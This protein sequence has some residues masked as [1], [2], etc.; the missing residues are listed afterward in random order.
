MIIDLHCDTVY[1]L[2]TD[3]STDSLDRN[4]CS[5]DAERMIKGGVS[6]QCFAIFTPINAEAPSDGLTD[7]QRMNGIHDRFTAELKRSTQLKQ[8]FSAADIKNDTHLAILTVEEL[9]PLEGKIERLEEIAS[10]GVRISGL[11]W[12]WENVYGYPNSKDPGIMSK[13]LK[14]KGFEALEFFR[15][16]DI[17][18]DVS[19][20][21]DGG[22]YDVINS[23]CKVLAT[24][25]NS[26]AITDVTRNLTDEMLKALADK[27]GV[28]GLNFCPSF[29]TS[30][31]DGEEHV[32]RVSDM[33]RHVMH[34]YNT[35]G[36]DVLALGTDFD[37]I[38]GVLEIPSPDY[39]YL[40]WDALRSAGLSER[41][42][43]KMKGTNALRVL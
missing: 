18:V 21:S 1:K 27:G 31:S 5:V 10:W 12:N 23:G 24:H 29:L 7:W 11:T 2:Y 6:G 35:A 13:G 41:I 8:A 17:A 20:L 28:A 3:E 36:E 39:L 38:G 30:F 42:I 37:G 19:H 26:R 16:H 32:S 25:S 22:F 4:S 15:E 33:V 34:I 40:L 14:E 9:G 43:D